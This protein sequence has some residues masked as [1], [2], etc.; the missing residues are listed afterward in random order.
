MDSE[1]NKAGRKDLSLRTGN[2]RHHWVSLSLQPLEYSPGGFEVFSIVG[3]DFV[4]QF[5]PLSLVA[6]LR[7]LDVCCHR[8]SAAILGF[9]GREAPTEIAALYV[10]N[11]A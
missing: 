9:E 3:D 7:C 2:G 10:G 11:S 5:L 4:H 1:A 6:G 8:P